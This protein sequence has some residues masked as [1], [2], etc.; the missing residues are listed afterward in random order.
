MSLILE[1]SCSASLEENKYK[2]LPV[3]RHEPERPTCPEPGQLK[4]ELSESD[5]FKL[6]VVE[7]EEDLVSVD[8]KE[9]AASKADQMPEMSV[10]RSKSSTMSFIEKIF[11]S[12]TTTTIT[13]GGK[14]K[15][16]M[17]TKSLN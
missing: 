2:S 6:N 12:T 9:D 17:I 7:G 5:I 3:T 8:L 4:K 11:S 16:T 1:L 13:T 10:P 15:M 14:L